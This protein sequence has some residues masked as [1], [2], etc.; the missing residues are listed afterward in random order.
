M[1]RTWRNGHAV[2]LCGIPASAALSGRFSDQATAG[3]RAHRE[4]P[5][6]SAPA[7]CRSS[8]HRSHHRTNRA[9]GCDFCAGRGAAATPYVLTE[10]PSLQEPLAVLRPGDWG[11]L[12]TGRNDY[13]PF[14]CGNPA[15]LA[16]LG[17]SSDQAPGG[18]TR[19]S[20]AP[21][22]IR[23]CDLTVARPSRGSKL[24]PEVRSNHWANGASG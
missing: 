14:P 7:T 18:E 9:S 6:G 12:R 20:G 22:G 21:S 13:I 3:E 8:D 11:V 17:G 2:F 23:T 4:L 16:P 1:L 10:I 5:A 15:C 19:S 24:R